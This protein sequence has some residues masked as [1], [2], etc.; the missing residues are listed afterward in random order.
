[1]KKILVLL[2]MGGVLFVAPIRSEA[3][4]KN[5][6]HDM[7]FNGRGTNE[8]VCSYCHIPHNATGDKIWS[9]WGISQGG[10]GTA[11]DSSIRSMCYTCHDGTVTSVGSATAFNASLQQHKTN[12]GTDCN[13]CHTVHDN[14][15][16]K[17]IGVQKTQSAATGAATYCETCHD[18][19]MYSGA[20]PH[21]DHLA[22]SEHPYIGGAVDGSCLSCHAMHGA[23]NYTTAGLTN[24]ILKVENTDSAL[25]ITCHAD[26][27]QASAGGFKHP[28]NTSGGTYD[29]L[30]CQ[31]CHDVH[32]PDASDRV[33]I[34]QED[35]TDSA[36]CTSCHTSGGA[37]GIGTHT[38][39]LLGTPAVITDSTPTT[40][41]PMGNAIDDDGVGGADYAGNTAGVVCESCH[42]PHQRGTAV[43]LLRITSDAGSL[44]INCHGDK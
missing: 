27:V 30:I 5:S 1:M 10:S 2:M 14:T 36:Y 37:P 17:F 8:N 18:S 44:C 23:A 26:N 6:L 20:E 25:C 3:S 41:T 39:P 9:D 31:T 13:I 4:V 15:N 19:T 35:N 43:P 42:S 40:G 34:L 24:P 29:K 16:G 11:P 12:V 38:H 22:G 28:A 33:A 21:G 7:F 32:Q